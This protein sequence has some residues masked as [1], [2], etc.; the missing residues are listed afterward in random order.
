MRSSLFPFPLSPSMSLGYSQE[1]MSIEILVRGSPLRE[2]P[3]EEQGP[4]YELYPSLPMLRRRARDEAQSE[5]R[6][7]GDKIY[8]I[9]SLPYT[10]QERI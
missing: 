2:M 7:Q 5:E 10:E 4:K 9:E 8:K 1:R 3:Q 6:V